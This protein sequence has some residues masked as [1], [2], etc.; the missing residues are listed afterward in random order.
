MLE[1]IS[2]YKCIIVITVSNLFDIVMGIINN[3]QYVKQ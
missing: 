2:R 1:C 3:K